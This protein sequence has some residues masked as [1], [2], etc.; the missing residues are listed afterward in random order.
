MLRVKKNHLRGLTKEQY[1]FLRLLCRRS[2][3][4]YNMAMYTTKQHYASCGEF[5]GNVEVWNKIKH[6][7]CYKNIPT[8]LSN[9]TM[10]VVERAYRSF[11][12]L[13]HKR[14]DGHYNRPVNEPWYQPKKGMF[15]LIFPIRA[16]RGNKALNINVPKQYQKDFSF[17]RLSIPRPD[18]TQGKELK[19]IRILPRLKGGYFEIEWVYEEDPQPQQLDSTRSLGIDP[20]VNNFATCVD[21]KSGRSFIL[22][23][24]QLKSYN[25]Y[26]NKQ[27]AHKQSVHDKIG[28]KTSKNKKRLWMKRNNILNNALNQYVNV[29]VHYCL[30][31]KV[32]NIVMGQGYMAQEGVNHGA[33]S[34]QNFVN[35]PFG[36][37][38]LKLKSKCEMYGITYESV[39][40]SYTSKC[41]HL[42]NEPMKHH[43]E[44]L[45]RRVKRGLFKS[46]TG[47]VLNADVNG[48]L[49]ILLKSKRDVD[50]GQ[51]TVSGCL[52]Q[53][54]R[55]RLADVQVGSAKSVANRLSSSRLWCAKPQPAGSSGVKEASVSERPSTTTG[56]PCG[57]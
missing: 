12:G 23:G 9:Q 53:P 56:L 14:R 36:K 38:C 15:M 26:V 35:L 29:I 4:I 43:E 34:N 27:S 46:S 10:K 54:S 3:A 5:I 31:N 1:R 18:Y 52:T 8:D 44:Y 13:L 11:F 41:D 47:V 28:L 25:R 20:G 6:T 19:E 39:E 49:G 51:L 16:G 57:T 42:A 33:K 21:S 50:L 7:Q 24:R 17:K 37:F 2:R 22:D 30:L 48:A 40:E 32:G 45:G 55:I